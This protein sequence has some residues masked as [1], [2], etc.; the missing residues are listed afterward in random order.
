MTVSDIKLEM[1]FNGVD[2]ADIAAILAVCKV[3]GYA[4]ETLDNELVKRG[5]SRVF[6]YNADE[7]EEDEWED[8]FSP[9]ERFPH[10][11]RFEDE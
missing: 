6:T 10:R 9:V 4:L 2:D 7:E 11:H 8:E 5:Y 1:K 3:K